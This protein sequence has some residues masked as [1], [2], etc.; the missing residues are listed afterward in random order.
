M[1]AYSDHEA[2]DYSGEARKRSIAKTAGIAAVV[3]GCIIWAIVII[4]YIVAVTVFAGTIN[5][6]YGK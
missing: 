2:K 3:I 6:Y 1:T 5:S 4:Y